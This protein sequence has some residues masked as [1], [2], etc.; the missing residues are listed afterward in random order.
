MTI[1]LTFIVW[2]TPKPPTHAQICCSYPTGC[3]IM[4][5][6]IIKIYNKKIEGPTLMELFTATGKLRKF[7]FLTTGDV[8]CVHHGLHG[9]HRYDIQV[10][11]THVSP[12]W[13]VCGR[14]LNI[15]LMCAVSSMVH[16]SNTS[17]C[18]K[19]NFLSFPVAVNNSIKVGPLVFLL[20]IFVITEN[21]MICPV[22]QLNLF[23]VPICT[24]VKVMSWSRN[25]ANC[26]SMR[27]YLLCRLLISAWIVVDTSRGD[28]SGPPVTEL[29][30][31][32]FTSE[33]K[34]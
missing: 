11:A 12:W 28:G 9:N 15:V 23:T 13:C 8:Q 18:Q 4:F 1:T 19:K 16:I 22:F 21:I 25:C 14:N 17:S 33:N 30:R 29:R 26:I 32:W 34:H 10:L 5:S 20:Q 31:G 24:G 6:V 7:F 27:L 2:N 3:F